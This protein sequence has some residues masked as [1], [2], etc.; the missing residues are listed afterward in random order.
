MVKKFSKNFYPTNRCDNFD[1]GEIE[2]LN[3]FHDDVAAIVVLFGH[4]NRV[5]PTSRSHVEHNR[6]SHAEVLFKNWH[7]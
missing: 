3:P 4:Q 5:A 6:A 7:T 2:K 1:V